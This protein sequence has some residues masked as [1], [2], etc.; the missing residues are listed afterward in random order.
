MGLDECFTFPGLDFLNCKMGMTYVS[1]TYFT[2]LL[3][4]PTAPSLRKG[5]NVF[6]SSL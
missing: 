3:L 4:P 1:P 5:D 6:K 2:A